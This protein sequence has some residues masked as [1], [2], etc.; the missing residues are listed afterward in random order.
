[1]Q[2]SLKKNTRTSLEPFPLYFVFLFILKLE[3]TYN[4]QRGEEGRGG[5]IGE[6]KEERY[7]VVFPKKE[8]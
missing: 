7:G 6:R 4:V 8:I 5:G 2:D 3:P 1:M